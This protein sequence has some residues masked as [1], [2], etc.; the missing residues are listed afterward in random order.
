MVELALLRHFASVSPSRM[1]RRIVRIE[2]EKSSIC[3][4]KIVHSYRLHTVNHCFPC[5]YGF[6]PTKKGDKAVNVNLFTV[7]HVLEGFVERKE[8]GIRNPECGICNLSNTHLLEYS[9]F[10]CRKSFRIYNNYF[11]FY[12]TGY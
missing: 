6:N 7:R 2:S 1:S 12:F 10:I 9:F 8:S 4:S 3:H 11:I 5:E